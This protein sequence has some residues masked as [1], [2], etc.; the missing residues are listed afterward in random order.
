MCLF[1]FTSMR[2]ADGGTEISEPTTTD[3]VMPLLAGA[4]LLAYRACIWPT[5]TTTEFHAQW[6]RL[7]EKGNIKE[8]KGAPN[9]M[10]TTT[11]KHTP[12]YM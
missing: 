4:S 3:T 10:Q 5:T 9:S 2:I 11:G 12:T 1:F 7:S 8:T 6:D